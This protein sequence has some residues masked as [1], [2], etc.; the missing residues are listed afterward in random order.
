VSRRP[1]CYLDIHAESLKKAGEELCGDTVR[2]L[3]GERG[4]T[5]V[6]SDGMGSGVKAN[7]LATLTA[8]I[9][10]KMLQREVSL[11]DTIETVLGTLPICKV[12]KLAYATFTVVQIDHA[13]G[14]FRLINFDNPPPFFFRRNALVRL[15]MRAE[16]IAGRRIQFAEGTLE[17]G[18]FLGI[19]SDGVLHA[20]LGVALNFGWGWENVARFL[21]G[22]LLLQGRSARPVVQRALGETR[23]LYRDEPGDDATFVGIVARRRNAAIV[24][25]GPPLDRAQD[26]LYVRRVLGFPGRTVVCGGTT[27]KIVGAY[28][29]RPIAIDVGTLRPDVPP[30]GRLPQVD[31]VTEGILTMAKALEYLKAAG[32]DPGRLPADR[33]GATLLAGEVLRADRVYFLV[34]QRINEFYQNPLLPKSIS[35]RRSLVEDLAGHIRRSG[36]EVVVEYC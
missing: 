28:L 23:R 12:R 30:I 15:P 16:E 7:I 3:R 34:G 11:S 10:L 13:D 2:V 24:F 27:A 21:E 36:R 31:L 29:G 8:E 14:R 18:D 22:S 20:G 26:E 6:L 4:T 17:Q 25:T 32:W 1:D 35:I 9:L 5:I 19:V 33:N